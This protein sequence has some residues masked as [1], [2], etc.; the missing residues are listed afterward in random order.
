MNLEEEKYLDIYGNSVINEET[1]MFGKN[2]L[3]IGK[4]KIL[5][6]YFCYFLDISLRILALIYLI[7]FIIMI[8]NLKV[9]VNYMFY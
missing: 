2:F 1:R 8:I 4:L 3:L 7:F 6:S 5:Q 9:S